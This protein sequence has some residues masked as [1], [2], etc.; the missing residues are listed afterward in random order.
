MTLA[1]VLFVVCGRRKRRRRRRKRSRRR[2]RRRRRSKRRIRRAW[3]VL[4]STVNAHCICVSIFV[5]FVF[6]YF[7]VD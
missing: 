2:R 5:N 4:S 1:K 3:V 6:G 7:H